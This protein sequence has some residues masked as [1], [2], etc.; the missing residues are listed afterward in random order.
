MVKQRKE[1]NRKKRSSKGF[2]A[3]SAK[4]A[5]GGVLWGTSIALRPLNF[6]INSLNS[7]SRLSAV[8]AQAGANGNPVPDQVEDKH[9]QRDCRACLCVSHADRS[10]CSS[11]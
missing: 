8:P 11:Q 10:P 2:T 7:H 3:N 1:N 4:A 6:A 9:F 5:Q